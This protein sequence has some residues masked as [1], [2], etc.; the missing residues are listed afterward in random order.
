MKQLEGILPLLKPAGM[1]SHDC[2]I[3]IR[4]LFQTKKVGH[5]GTLD[6]DVVG[7]LPIC[8]GR[9]T[10]VAQYMSDYTKTYIGEATIGYS[11][12]TE[13]KSGEI[14]ER[15]EVNN[16]W[17]KDEILALLSSF[18]GEITQVPPMYSAVKVNGKKLY[19]YARKN[20]TVE[21][22]KR[23]V[24][25]FELDLIGDVTYNE[26]MKTF[27]FPFKVI[28][29]KG[30]YVRTLAVDLG[31][32]LGF[33]AHM[34]ALKRTASGPYT[35]EMCTTLEE[36]EA[37]ESIDARVD[38]LRPL[39]EAV[40]HLPKLIVDHT[41]E[42]LIKYGSVLPEEKGLDE[43]RFTVY[44]EQGECLAIYQK[45]PTKPGLIK[46]EKMIWTTS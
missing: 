41:V 2:V 44:N 28:C 46:P 1:T 26:G 24:T 4:R 8:I 17:S 14:V 43:L 15:M 12:T 9:A 6:P 23:Q 21:R 31:K 27:S 33:P 11:T 13:D 42:Q 10:K 16:P 3:K 25:I 40:Q 35:T 5:T 22:P 30:T 36:L 34:S 19:E 39:D 32:T 37:L 45:H 7:V 20:Q 18:K 29:S 38:K